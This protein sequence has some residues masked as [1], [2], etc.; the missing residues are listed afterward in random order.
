VSNQL[1]DFWN[2][3]KEVR[4]NQFKW[5]DSLCAIAPVFHRPC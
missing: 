1:E 4:T 2:A 5:T 3:M